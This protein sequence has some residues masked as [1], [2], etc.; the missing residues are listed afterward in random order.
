V[1]RELSPDLI[2]TAV[3]ETIVP[4]ERYEAFSEL[5]AITSYMLTSNHALTDRA[6][7]LN[8]VIHPVIVIKA[9]RA[10]D[11][12]LCVGGVRSLALA[13]AS[14]PREAEIAVTLITRPR[15]ADIELL[16]GADIL[17][18]HLLFS[19]RTPVTVGKI[20]Q[21]IQKEHLASLLTKGTQSKSS[22]ASFLGYA[23]N[24]V[25][26]PPKKAGRTP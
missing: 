6:I 19:L 4:H 10:K 24:T 23:L 11:R 26:P 21:K 16:I 14:L 3:I 1:D 5:L 18:T 7:Q 12:Y 25:F 15:P 17:L 8:L 20:F 13:K 9:K 22:L 2:T